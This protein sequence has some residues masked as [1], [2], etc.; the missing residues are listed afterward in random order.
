MRTHLARNDAG[1]A[2]PAPQDEGQLADLR[3]PRGHDPLDVL[4]ALRQE[5]GQDQGRQRELQGHRVTDRQA[6][7]GA[8]CPDPEGTRAEAANEHRVSEARPR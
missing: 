8:A 1:S 6:G 7:D 3:Q 2:R 4:A 5:H